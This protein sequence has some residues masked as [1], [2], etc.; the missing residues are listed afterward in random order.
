MDIPNLNLRLAWLWILL[1]FA[2][3]FA[4]G[5]RF[6][7][8]NWL[9]GYASHKR[10]LYRLCHISFFGLALINL[11]FFF[12]IRAHSYPATPTAVASWGFIAGALSMPVC[13]LIMAHQP[14]WRALFLVPVL[15]LMMAGGITLW[16]IAT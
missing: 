8:E 16:E 11:M 6:H 9:G 14:K 2:S 5:A 7:E 15:S 12:T 13:C 3:G 1:G 4:L 10:R